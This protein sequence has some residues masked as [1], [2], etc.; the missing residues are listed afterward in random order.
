ML[1][2]FRKLVHMISEKPLFFTF[3]LILKSNTFKKDNVFTD[4]K[5]NV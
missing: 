4:K 5:I 2:E 3:F 1:F